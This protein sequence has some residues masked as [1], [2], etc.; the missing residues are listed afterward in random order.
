M[1]GLSIS[2]V[3]STSSFQLMRLAGV[4]LDLAA[5]LPRAASEEE[6][7]VKGEQARDALDAFVDAAA[8]TLRD[9]V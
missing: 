5:A 7:G 3:S 8:A 4:V 2:Y 1:A 6:L 9:P